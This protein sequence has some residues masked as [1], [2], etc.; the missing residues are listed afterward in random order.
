[1][2]E[3]EKVL[4][5]FN[6][7]LTEKEREEFERHL[8]SCDECREEIE[9]L[10]LLTED[11]PFSTEPVDP[12]EGM[13]D[14]VLGAVFAEKESDSQENNVVSF[15]ERRKEETEPKEP[16]PKR[17]N[18][19]WVMRGLAAA[20]TL[21][22][23]GNILV[24]TGGDEEVAN[25]PPAVDSTD[26]VNQRV[27]LQ[28]EATDASAIAAMIRQNDKNLLTLQAE[29]LD[30][31]QGDEVY[32]VWL[33]EGDKPYRA[34]TFVANENGEGAVAYSMDDLPADADWD[35]VAISKEPDAT[36][37]TPQGD[38]ILSSSL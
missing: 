17:N 12:P 16:Q 23:L 22:L 24:L 7:E 15:E 36:S 14:R 1:M 21:S 28:G 13:K 26:I 27:Q 8:A 38:V 18:Q 10:Q 9:E 25:E 5:Y 2:R 20:L 11:L 31:L 32:Q 3:C 35:A 19:R 6:H 29:Q 33:L 34:G 30:Q 4:D 37:E